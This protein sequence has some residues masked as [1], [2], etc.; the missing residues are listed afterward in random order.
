MWVNTISALKVFLRVKGRL[1][2]WIDSMGVI[3]DLKTTSFGGPR[4]IGREI[5]RLGYDIQS[6]LYTDGMIERTENQDIK[7]YFIFVRSVPPYITT[8]YNGHNTAEM[9]G[10]SLGIGRGWYREA[11]QKYAECARSGIWREF[12]SPDNPESK[13][14]DPILPSYA[15]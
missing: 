5:W 9:A 12:F 2:Y 13:V 1:D 11:L 7:F 3:A 8:V 6:A 15:C 4:A 14:L 10:Q